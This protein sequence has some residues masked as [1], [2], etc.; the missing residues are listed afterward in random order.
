[1]ALNE[2]VCYQNIREIGP[3]SCYIK[4]GSSPCVTEGC[5]VEDEV[6]NVLESGHTPSDSLIQ[7]YLHTRCRL[8]SLSTDNKEFFKRI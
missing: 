5:P 2:K 1:M 8:S 7:I 4:A 6:I 3:T